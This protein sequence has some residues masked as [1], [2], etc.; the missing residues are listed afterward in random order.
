MNYKL[1]RLLL[2][3]YMLLILGISSF[4]GGSFPRSTLL[5][6]DKL[7][8]FIEYFFLGIFAMKSMKKQSFNNLTFIIPSGIVFALSDEYLQSF[9][10][11][12]FSSGWDVLSDSIGLIIGA[13]LIEAISSR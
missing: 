3:A 1:F 12:R 10:D 9:I 6:W 7:I 2:A 5:Q 13:V 8:H 4:P 11:G